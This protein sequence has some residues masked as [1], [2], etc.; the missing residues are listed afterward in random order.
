MK[1]QLLVK[2]S[3]QSQL[4][5]KKK[6]SGVSA[7]SNQNRPTKSITTSAIESLNKVLIKM[8]T[9]STVL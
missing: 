3:L 8:R 1:E 4:T 2:K 5:G 6:P 7:Y 9:K